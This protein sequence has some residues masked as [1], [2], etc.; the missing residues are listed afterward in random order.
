[1]SLRA[2]AREMGMSS[3]AIYRYFPS[4]DALLTQLIIDA[5]NAIGEAA[6][7]ARDATS[8]S[9]PPTQLRAVWR[10]IRDWALDHPHEYAL[11]YGSPVPGY[12]AP[13]DTIAPASRVPWT[14]LGILADAK[15][16]PSQPR[17]GLRRTAKAL[18]PLRAQIPS[19][20]AVTDP[21]LLAAL[22]TWSGL[23]GAISFEIFGQL[24]NVID[25][26]PSA[27]EAYFD[28]QIDLMLTLL[29]M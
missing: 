16:A 27:R 25:S 4:R 2:V 24:Q 23:F 14:L 18:G 3:S 7:S 12:Q 6:E 1:M 21:V 28:A 13:E 11:I 26:D 5:Y 22:T 20:A 19:E 8:R 9:Q 29:G 10:A 17:A 15:A